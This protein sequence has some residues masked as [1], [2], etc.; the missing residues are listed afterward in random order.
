MKKSVILLIGLSLAFMIPELIMLQERQHS[1]TCFKRQKDSAP[2]CRFRYAQPP[3]QKTT[4]LEPFSDSIL[5]SERDVH[6]SRWKSISERL[7]SI[8]Q[9]KELL[10]V[11]LVTF[12]D[13]EK[14]T[15]EE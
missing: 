10:D 4:I 13:D 2:T 1:N 3:I 14:W 8:D 7:K 15:E 6:C 5:E 12:L 9:S 11:D